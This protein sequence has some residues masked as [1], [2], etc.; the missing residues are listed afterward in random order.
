MIRVIYIKVMLFLCVDFCEVAVRLYG[1]CIVMV[2]SLGGV[3]F[4]DL[5]ITVLHI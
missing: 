2:G 5:V 3:A 1:I 4:A